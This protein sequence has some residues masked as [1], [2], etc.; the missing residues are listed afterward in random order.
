L[1]ILGHAD[2]CTEQL[3]GSGMKKAMANWTQN[4]QQR[5]IFSLPHY[6]FLWLSWILLFSALVWSCY[7]DLD[8]CF[9]GN[10]DGGV[11]AAAI[12]LLFPIYHCATDTH[13]FQ[14]W[15]SI[16]RSSYSVSVKLNVKTVMRIGQVDASYMFY[17]A[18]LWELAAQSH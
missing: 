15:V 16:E 7:L 10:A 1:V 13:H 18:I 4:D 2:V 5:F 8:W 6:E 11:V 9:E 12:R 17:G 3:Y 14:C